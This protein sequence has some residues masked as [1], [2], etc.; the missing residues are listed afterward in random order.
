MSIQL[1][2]HFSYKR[3]IRFVLPSILMMIFYSLY[4]LVDGF[5]VSNFVGKTEFAALNFIWPVI[6]AVSGVG[7]MIA[8]GGSAYVAKLLGEGKKD[9]ANHA[10]SLLIY[11]TIILCIFISIIFIYLTPELAYMLGAR[12][13]FHYHCVVYGRINFLGL[14]FYV[15]QSIFQSFFI[16]AEKPHLSLQVSILSGII[17][18]VLDFIFMGVMG[19][20]LASAAYATIIG[21]F[22][23]A[24][25]PFIY[26][27]SKNNSRLRLTKT[28]FKLETITKSYSNGF[29]EMVTNIS[30]SIVGILFNFQLMNIA[31]ENGVAAYGAI[32]YV[33]FF[34]TAINIGYSMGSAPI[35][36]YNYGANNTLELQ[37]LFKKSLILLGTVGIT[38]TILSEALAVPLVKV[39]ASYDRTLFEV[40]LHGFRVYV[41]SFLL[42][43]FN[44]W[45]SAFFTALNNGRIS[46]IL[47]FFRTF[48]FQVVCVVLLP[49]LFGI[50]GIWSS[51]I[52]AEIL[53]SLLLTYF[54]VSAR[55]DY[56]YY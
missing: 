31:G 35:V 50:D 55:P 27:L 21:Q 5:F 41:I 15:I 40:T 47:S 2:D 6:Q 4:T 36:S 38:M 18:A 54:I 20:G 24:V 53:S 17:N 56:N 51:I 12:G 8:T 1:S 25:I 33:V 43:G 39:F 49:I 46:A 16:V 44:M 7:F 29:S 3:L 45:G 48:V 42:N 11:S 52:I 34:F 30:A 14:T 37:N 32:M 13:D 23:G 10:F 9:D 19:L 26:F 28:S 22:V